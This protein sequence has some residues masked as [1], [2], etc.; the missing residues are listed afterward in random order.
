MET[1]F[2]TFDN[3]EFEQLL[4]EI[5]EQTAY[6]NHSEALMS[7]A[8]FFGYDEYYKLFKDY[9]ERD[10]LSMKEFN[11]RCDAKDRMFIIIQA[12]YGADVIKRINEVM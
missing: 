10:G 12:E 5:E 11:A 3:K 8:D 6:N 9:S 7:I 1:K 4:E 2:K